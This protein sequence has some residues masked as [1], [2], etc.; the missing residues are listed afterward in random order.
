M[1][2]GIQAANTPA[3]GRVILNSG[4]LTTSDSNNIGIQLNIGGSAATIRV[5]NGNLSWNWY[6]PTLSNIGSQYE[7]RVVISIGSFTSGPPSGTWVTIDGSISLWQR[8]V[9][10]TVQGLLEVRIASVDITVA[11]QVFQLTRT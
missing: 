1:T 9:A 4:A 11:S 8:N 2:A 7:C 10:G 3:A 5:G 6:I